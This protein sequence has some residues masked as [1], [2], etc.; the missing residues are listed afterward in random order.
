MKAIRVGLP[1]L[2]LHWATLVS[3]KMCSRVHLPGLKP[4]CSSTNISFSSNHAEIL[5]LRMVEN[6]LYGTDRRGIPLK[7]RGTLASS[8]VFMGI[9][10]MLPFLHTE[11]ML[12]FLRHIVKRVPRK[13]AQKSFL[14]TTA[15]SLS[16]PGAFLFFCTI[17]TCFT[18]SGNANASQ[19]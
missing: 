15:G 14:S 16:G 10:T 9:G 3:D 5:S 6:A 13:E 2:A 8:V 1:S 12:Q 19:L 17:I 18:S 7:F 11:G 4:F